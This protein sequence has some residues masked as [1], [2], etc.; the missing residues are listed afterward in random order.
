MMLYELRIY[1]IATGKMEDIHNRFANYTLR[2]FAKHDMHVRDFW[3]ETEPGHNRLCYVMEYPDRETRDRKI[4]AFRSDPEWIEVTAQSE[5]RGPIVE[6]RES[7]FLKKAPF[8]P[9]NSST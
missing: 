8:F 6:K 4:D 3:V 1:H 9:N 7:I 2:L 5:R